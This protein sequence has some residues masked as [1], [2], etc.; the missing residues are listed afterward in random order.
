MTTGPRIENITFIKKLVLGYMTWMSG[1]VGISGIYVRAIVSDLGM[2]IHS[3]L[4]QTLRKW[5]L[6]FLMSKV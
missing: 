2:Y 4:D 3:V 5:S 6:L 1:D